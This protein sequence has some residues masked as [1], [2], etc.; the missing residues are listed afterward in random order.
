MTISFVIDELRDCAS[1]IT[2]LSKITM[3]SLLD[4]WIINDGINTN[5]IYSQ[6][7]GEVVYMI[8]SNNKD[9][10]GINIKGEVFLQFVL[11][12]K[13]EIL[14]VHPQNLKINI[15][16]GSIFMGIHGQY[17][18]EFYKTFYVTEGLFFKESGDNL[19]KILKN[20]LY[21]AGDSKDTQFNGLYIHF[22]EQHCIF[23]CSNR[24][25]ISIYKGINIIESNI[26]PQTCFI[27]LKFIQNLMKILGKL[28]DEIVYFYLKKN[29]LTIKIKNLFLSTTI[30]F[31]PG[32]NLQK[33]QDF[34]NNKELLHIDINNLTHIINCLKIISSPKYPLL[35]MN[36]EDKKI[37]LDVT[38]PNLG[39]MTKTIDLINPIGE[40]IIMGVNINYLWDTLHGCPKDSN[41][42]INRDN[43]ILFVKYNEYTHVIL[44]M[45]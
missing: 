44:S 23:V 20:I 33:F 34:F 27:S 36:I 40:K 28:K 3:E 4:L 32:I 8:T 6:D 7:W 31:F 35:N 29:I 39:E 26:N 42:F 41:I 12:S 25:R 1:I 14:D 30:Q 43:K 19:L 37:I 10:Y 2:K 18:K 22:Q 21:S 13:G 17:T 9:I 45:G 5:I 24:I 15:N 16:D 11:K 38:E